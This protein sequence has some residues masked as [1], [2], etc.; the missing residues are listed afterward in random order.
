VIQIR[1]SGGAYPV[2]FEPLSG[3]LQAAPEDC[4]IVTDENVV[5]AWG[6][7]IGNERPKLVLP[8]GETTKSL[9]WLER[10]AAW[11]AEKGASRKSTIVALGGGVIGDLVGFAAATYMRGVRYIQ[12]PTTLLAQVDSSVG[13]KVAVDIPQGKNLVGAFYPPVQVSVDT[14]LLDTLSPRQLRNGLA[15]VWKYAFIMDAPL[16]D[17]LRLGSISREEIIQTCIHHKARIVAEDEFETK[18]L[19]AILN[20]GHT[21]GHAIEQV[22]SYSAFLH[23]EAISIGMVAEC[24]L[25]ENLGVTPKGT[26]TTLR[27]CLSDQGLPISWEGLQDTE[28]LL[29]AMRKDKKAARGTLAF[30]LLTQIG[31]CKLVENVDQ[32]DVVRALELL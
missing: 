27:Q 7:A 23:G 26:V 19:R 1:H 20:F 3:A 4:F 21:I 30:S 16:A 10:V 14:A 22:T 6:H 24:L 28:P 29:E 12:I 13:G 2:Q 9:I 17:K 15:E 11:L 8:P 31:G 25:G 5:R 32:R 18:G